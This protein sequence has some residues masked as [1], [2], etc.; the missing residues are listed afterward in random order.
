[1]LG[2]GGGDLLVAALNDSVVCNAEYLDWGRIQLR[3]RPA[4][5]TR[6]G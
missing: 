1:M 3:A 6:P 4:R 2:F 5:G